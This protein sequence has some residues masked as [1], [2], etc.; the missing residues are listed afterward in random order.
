MFGG[1]KKPPEASWAPHDWPKEMSS[2]ATEDISSVATEDISSVAAEEI[3]S[4]ATEDI[5]LGQS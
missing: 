4:V 5:S 1:P 2:V 3:S